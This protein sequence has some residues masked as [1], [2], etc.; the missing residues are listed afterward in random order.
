MFTPL[1]TSA[2][3]RHHP[4]MPNLE[5]IIGFM[6][7]LIRTLLVDGLSERV[8]S[9]LRRLIPRRQPHGMA[10]VRRHLHQRT[11]RRVFNRLSTL[12]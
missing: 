9:G 7:E 1:A 10:G 3:Q 2:R 5:R 8:R 11:R 4:P 12:R 6:A